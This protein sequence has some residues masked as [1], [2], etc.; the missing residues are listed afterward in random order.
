MSADTNKLVDDALEKVVELG[1]VGAMK[2][3]HDQVWEEK[4]LLVQRKARLSIERGIIE[5]LIDDPSYEYDCGMDA[6]YSTPLTDKVAVLVRK[7]VQT[8]LNDAQKEAIDHIRE[9]M[10]FAYKNGFHELGY[11]PLGVLKASLY[12]I[13]AD[14][15]TDYIGQGYTGGTCFSEPEG[16]GTI[17]LHYTEIEQAEAAFGVITCIADKAKDV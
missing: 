9:M 1:T 2:W 6:D 3:L 12:E 15:G 11:D 7:K 8:G 10:Q 14:F 17:R 13:S 16:G 4:R 5:S